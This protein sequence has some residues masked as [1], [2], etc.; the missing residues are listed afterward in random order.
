MAL[1]LLCDRDL[2]VKNLLFDG[3]KIKNKIQYYLLENCEK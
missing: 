1:I 2:Q 3:G